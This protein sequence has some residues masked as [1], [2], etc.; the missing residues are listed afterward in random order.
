MAR[1]R[2]PL[3]FLESDGVGQAGRE[4]NAHVPRGD[5]GSHDGHRVR[6][7]P[8]EEAVSGEGRGDA[9]GV[10]TG[11]AIPAHRAGIL[12]GTSNAEAYR[13]L[14]SA[15]YTDAEIGKIDLEDSAVVIEAIRKG[16][17]K[18]AATLEPR[19]RLI[20]EADLPRFLAEGWVARM[21]VNGSQFVVERA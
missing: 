6:V 4:D 14:L 21:P 16:A 9:G 20:P 10:P 12:S 1:L 5:D 8:R 13:V 19:Q 2:P 3:V 7:P 17:A 18:G 11:R 15:W